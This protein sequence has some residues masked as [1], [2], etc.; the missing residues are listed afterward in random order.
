LLVGLM[1]LVGTFALFA[2]GKQYRLQEKLAQAE[3]QQG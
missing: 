2:V 3:T 1:P